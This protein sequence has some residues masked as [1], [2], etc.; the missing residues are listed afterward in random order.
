MEDLAFLKSVIE[1]AR[2]NGGVMDATDLFAQALKGGNTE[3]K[4]ILLYAIVAGC[5]HAYDDRQIA[6]NQEYM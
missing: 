5:F 4:Q 1:V 2:K 3:Q 6:L